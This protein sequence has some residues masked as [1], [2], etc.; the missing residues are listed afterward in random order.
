MPDSQTAA[1]IASWVANGS[2]A[3]IAALL[4]AS[5]R[6]DRLQFFPPPARES[7]Q[8]HVFRSLFRTFFVALTVLSVLRFDEARAGSD[9]GQSATF[10]ATTL[11]VIGFGTA[12]ACTVQMGW[13]NAFGEQR[14]LVTDGWFR[15]SRNPVYVASWMGMGGWALLV[16]TLEVLIPLTL[17]AMVYG[18]APRLEERWLSDRYGRSYEE[19]A[20]RT[21]RFLFGR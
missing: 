3:L 13:R 8:F 1:Q 12:T 11:L 7:W 21:P 18:V 9:G 2:A 4:I 5:I 14:G 17:W 16:P 6:S 19:Y 10:V 15:F 20:A